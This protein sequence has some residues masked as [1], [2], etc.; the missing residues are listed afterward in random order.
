MGNQRPLLTPPVLFAYHRVVTSN[1]VQ[2]NE[3][4]ISSIFLSPQQFERGAAT[5]GVPNNPQLDLGALRLVQ[6]VVG[7]FATRI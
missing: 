5:V 4:I 1:R 2:D 3:L 6:L 7:V